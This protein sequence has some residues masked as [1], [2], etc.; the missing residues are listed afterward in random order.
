M[1]TTWVVVAESSRARILST[2]SVH[3]PLTEIAALDRPEARMRE[4]ELTSDVPGRPYVSGG[5]RRHGM[6]DPVRWHD[7]EAVRFAREVGGHL[8]AARRA[9]RFERL[10]LAAPPRFLGRLREE[11]TPAT[12]ATV[13]HE[14]DK[15]WLH[16]DCTAI[17]EHLPEYL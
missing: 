3:E 2:E 14:Y 10:I 7:Q 4:R 9:G 12:A 1:S 15:N 17:R 16:D 6:A 8:E 11:L 5:T 13:V